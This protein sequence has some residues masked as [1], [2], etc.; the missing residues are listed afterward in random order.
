M[1]ALQGIL[2]INNVS[3]EHSDGSREGSGRAASKC[4]ARLLNAGRLKIDFYVIDSVIFHVEQR[5]YSLFAGI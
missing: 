4:D 2:R 5:E 3:L 1:K